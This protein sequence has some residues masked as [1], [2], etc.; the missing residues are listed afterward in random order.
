LYEELVPIE[1]S[2]LRKAALASLFSHVPGAGM[3]VVLANG[4]PYLLVLT[5]PAGIIIVGAAT[6]IARGL[7]RGLERRILH[8]MRVPKRRRKAPTRR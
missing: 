3:G 2:P 6:G 4:H 1:E 5:V 7:Q 8:A